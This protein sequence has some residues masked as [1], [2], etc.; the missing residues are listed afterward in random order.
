MIALFHF[1]HM[2]KNNL[3][4]GGQRVLVSLL[5]ITFA[6]MT[7]VTMSMLAQSIKS[8]VVL[9]P[10][11]LLGGDLSLA[12]KTEDTLSSQDIDQL[13]ALQQKGE[14]S[15]YTLI[16]FNNTSIMFHT[17]G[18]GDM[19]FIPNG[20]GIQPETYP[21]AGSLTI[22]EPQSIALQTLLKQVGDV[23]ITH[24][25]AEAYDLKLGDSIVLSDLSVGVPVAGVVRGIAYDTP[26]HRGEKV[27][28]SIET[29]Q[30]LAN[31][32]PV[33]NT[34][35]V[36]SAQ[37]E[38]VS[39]VLEGS[40]WSVD[41]AA[42]RMDEKAANL[43]LTGLR[44]AGILGLL[45]GG[46]GIANT[47]QVLLRRR[48]REIAI[49]KTLG[50]QAGHLR[51][52]FSLEAGLLGIVGSLLGSGLGVLASTGLLRLFR[53]T[54]SLLYQWTFSPVPPL[55]GVL[56]GTLTTVIFAYWAI[57]VSSQAS[58]MSLLRNEPVKVQ[59]LPGCQS[60]LLI[61]FLSILF[62]ALTSLVMESLLA[63]IGVLLGIAIGLAMLGAFF[64]GLL[65]V[66]TR[67]FHFRGFPLARMAFTSLRRRGLALI[68]AM[69]ALFI[70]AI[71]MSVGLSVAQF[72]QLRITGG[73]ANLE[74]YNLTILSTA[75]QESAIRQAV[76]E[77]HP[78]NAAV[79]YRTA[80]A[81]LRVV[82][83][84]D[85]IP[86]TDA[87]LVGRS[88]P[89]DYEVSGAKWGSQPDG[90]YAYKWANLKPGSQVQATF[91]DGSTRNFTVIGSYDINYRS[92]NLYPPTGLLMTAEAFTRVARP[93]SLTYFV[94]VP[95]NQ[96]TRAASALGTALPR[97]TV[98]N[99]V[100]Y[101]ARF[102]QSYQHLYFLPMIMA[103]LA[104]LAGILLVAN[105]VT[106]AMLDR[107]YEIGILKTLGYTRRQVLSIFAIEYGLAGLL[108]AVTGVLLIQGLLALLAIGNHQPA[109]ILLLNLPNIILVAFCGVGLTLLTVLGV[110]WKPTQ[111][112]PVMVLNDGAG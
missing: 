95:P 25:I 47:M 3:L 14:I 34:V 90:V 85:F 68:F 92:M 108:A 1:I 109:L 110:T 100:A 23:V 89:A 5:C 38:T 24:D 42:G 82:G 21:L 4:R 22:G 112:T 37:A 80:L 49:W 10:A 65:W 71:S 6:V 31:G 101:A 102:M 93:D 98:I 77:Q 33:V 51:L 11:Q 29:A 105:S 12:R 39:A 91:R 58:P 104:M 55:V 53:Q 87:V 48:Q 64:S 32:Q 63:G 76:E 94:Q 81:S 69:I 83:K 59:S 52:I 67:I 13:N 41:W 56:V 18:V 66:C 88:D 43:W 74:G 70:G 99:L 40:G 19:H 78:Q 61:L 7:L 107:R 30:Q 45:V 9:T 16:A 27:Y 28:Y 106:L 103:G 35:I 96:L 20:M 72:S 2:A 60:V 62:T 54:S 8:A 73:A 26:N 50:Y 46:I 17:P 86:A 111:V 57:I 15:R 84:D 97:A 36:N 75:N 44:G 79:G